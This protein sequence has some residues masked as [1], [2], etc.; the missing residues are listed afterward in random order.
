[1]LIQVAV[2]PVP[3]KVIDGFVGD[4]REVA[5]GVSEGTITSDPLMKL[6]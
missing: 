3:H 4:L 6:L 2:D 1:M 5:M